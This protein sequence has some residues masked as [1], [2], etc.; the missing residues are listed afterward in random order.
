[1]L[2]R[3][4]QFELSPATRLLRHD[5]VP[6]A[7]PRRAFDCL[8]FLDENR[9]RAIGR[10]ELAR[11]VWGRDN[12]SDNQIAQAIASLRRMIGD[13]GSEGPMLRTVP[14]FGYHWTGLVE[15]EATEAAVA[16]APVATSI[17]APH[18][19]DASPPRDESAPAPPPM[20]A[21][22]DASGIDGTPAAGTPAGVLT[23]M[24]ARSRRH[25]ARRWI[26]LAGAAATLAFS[27][28]LVRIA[29]DRQ[30]PGEAVVDLPEPTWILP[31]VVPD[32]PG[33]AWARVAAMA[34]TGERLRAHD[35]PVV[36]IENVLTLVGDADDA[37]RAVRGQGARRTVHIRAQRDGRRWHVVLTA[38]RDDGPPEVVQEHGD[39]L[40]A[41]VENAADDLARFL[42]GRTAAIAAADREPRLEVIRQFIRIGD[43]DAAREQ[44]RRLSGSTR[45]SI[46]AR[47]VD[48]AID[49]GAGAL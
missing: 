43:T 27:V 49:V 25:L 39:E 13:R 14:A 32:D 19:V 31:A 35:V 46:Q 8:V 37:E 23:S 17:D 28:V 10:D 24:P 41:T 7:M 2:H 5:G 45:D 6:V 4:L 40:L 44:M 42:G 47:L 15:I 38:Q 1:M 20:A 12:V 36:P 30:D 11:V 3:F 18:A 33:L 34:M 29:T 48:I 9:D 26:R 22:D 21:D 16:Q